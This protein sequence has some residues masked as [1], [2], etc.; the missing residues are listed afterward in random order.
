[1]TPEKA[2][3]LE[4]KLKEMASRAPVTKI[5]E[6]ECG[7]LDASDV[8]LASISRYIVQNDFLGIKPRVRRSSTDAMDVDVNGTPNIVSYSPP[9]GGEVATEE[10]NFDDYVRLFIDFISQRPYPIFWLKID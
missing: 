10:L 6:E 9:N 1:M 3:K 2:Q 7:E 8:V 4:S 5:S